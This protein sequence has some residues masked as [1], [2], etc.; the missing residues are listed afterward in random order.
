MTTNSKIETTTSPTS[1]FQ[2]RKKTNCQLLPQLKSQPSKRRKK[3]LQRK[4]ISKAIRLP[5][6]LPSSSHPPLKSPTR[7][8]KSPPQLLREVRKNA[9][10]LPPSSRWSNPRKKS[11]RTSKPEAETNFSTSA[12]CKGPNSSERAKPPSKFKKSLQDY[13]STTPRTTESGSSNQGTSRLSRAPSSTPT[14]F[15]ST[16][17]KPFQTQFSLPTA[18]NSFNSPGKTPTTNNPHF[19]G[20]TSYTPTGPLK[21]SPLLIPTTSRQAASGL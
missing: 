1:S 11:S 18:P 7:L 4:E 2:T 21:R 17:S 3:E 10:S 16:K 20:R 15:I 14:S 13:Q 19:P 9:K 5:I 6:K 12:R 8:L